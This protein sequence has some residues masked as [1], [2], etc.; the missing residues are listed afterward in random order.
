MTA[1]ERTDVDGAVVFFGCGCER[2]WVPLPVADLWAVA[3]RSV[4]SVLVACSREEDAATHMKM[5][6]PAR[7][8]VFSFLNWISHTI[9]GCRMT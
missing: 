4:R 8:V 3:D 1:R 9:D 6:C 5:Y 2:K 7:V